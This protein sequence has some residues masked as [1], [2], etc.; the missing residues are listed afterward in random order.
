MIKSKLVLAVL[1]ILAVLTVGMITGCSSGKDKDKPVSEFIQ[2][3]V[4]RLEYNEF[5]CVT[6]KDG[7]GFKIQAYYNI[8]D[9][10]FIVYLNSKGDIK[11]IDVYKGMTIW[12]VLIKD[13]DSYSGTFVSDNDSIVTVSK[14]NGGGYYFIKCVNPGTTTMRFDGESEPLFTVTVAGDWG[15]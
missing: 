4:E 12:A 3:Y 7:S 10:G 5:C 6:S 11:H 8:H 13:F 2:E 1:L 9:L 15:G 14:D